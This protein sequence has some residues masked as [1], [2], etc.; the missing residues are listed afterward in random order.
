MSAQYQIN[1]TNITIGVEPEISQLV[2]SN[3]GDGYLLESMSFG[4]MYTDS[5]Y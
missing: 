2:L 5:Q 1:A 4:I 3:T